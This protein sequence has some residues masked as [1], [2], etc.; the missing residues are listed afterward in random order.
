MKLSKVRRKK[1]KS[2]VSLSKRTKKLNNTILPS[3]DKDVEDLDEAL[4]TLEAETEKDAVGRSKDKLGFSMGMMA[5]SLN[6][7]AHL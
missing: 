4:V 2:I 6:T 3:V 5:K 7:T 1:L